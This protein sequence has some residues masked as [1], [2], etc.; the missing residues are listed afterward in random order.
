MLRS[1]LTL[2]VVGLALYAGCGGTTMAD[3]FDGVGTS[4]LTDAGTSHNDA[5]SGSGEGGT[6]VVEAG[7]GSYVVSCSGPGQCVLGAPG[8]CGAGCGEPTAAS[9]V[10]IQRGQEQA[11]FAATCT[12]T[13]AQCPECPTADEPSI[14]AFCRENK[15]VVVDIR[16]DGIASCNND[17][18]CMLRPA[19]CCPCN[20]VDVSRLVAI[21]KDRDANYKQQVC[22]PAV[23]CPACQWRYDGAR[24][25][26]SDNHCVVDTN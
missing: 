18:E 1:S 23:K 16:K 26:C 5:A 6:T 3:A 2:V 11:L 12:Q 21:R 24:P 13:N 7:S 19:E 4:S 17:E 20:Q 10:G 9:Y 25:K 14:Q 15:C 22:D 8:C